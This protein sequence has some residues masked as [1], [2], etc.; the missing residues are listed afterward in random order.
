MRCL[1]IYLLRSL[2]KKPGEFGNARCNG[3]PLT[4]FQAIMKKRTGEGLCKGLS[5]RQKETCKYYGHERSGRVL[6]EGSH[7]EQIQL[8]IHYR[9]DAYLKQKKKEKEKHLES[10]MICVSF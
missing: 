5:I 1:P 6:P 9:P 7:Q 4:T 10:Q 8:C 2:E 3:N